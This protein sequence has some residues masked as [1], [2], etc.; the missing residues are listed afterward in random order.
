MRRNLL[1]TT[2][3]AI[4]MAGFVLAYLAIRPPQMQ[5]SM[6]NAEPVSQTEGTT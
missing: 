3:V 2:L 1:V 6:D 4:L 5:A